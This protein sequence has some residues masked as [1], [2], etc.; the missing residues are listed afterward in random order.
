[1][2]GHTDPFP[3]TEERIR[4]L[5]LK[6]WVVAVRLSRRSAAE[7]KELLGDAWVHQTLDDPYAQGYVRALKHIAYA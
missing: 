6:G 5:R 2:N 7:A 3:E 1:M 4:E